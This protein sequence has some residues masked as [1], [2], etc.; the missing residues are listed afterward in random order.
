MEQKFLTYKGRPFV[1]NGNII[2]YGS[3]SDP[4][5][6]KMEVKSTKPIQ[7]K[8]ASTVADVSDK[9]RIQLLTT[10]PKVSPKRQ[11]LKV[12]DR[13]GIYMALDTAAFWLDRAIAEFESAQQ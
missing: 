13:E 3:M 11:I 9:I 12:G 10:D 1:R 6:V 4:F 8:D 2:Y 5:V 7:G